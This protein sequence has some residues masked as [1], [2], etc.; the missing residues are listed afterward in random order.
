[1][2]LGWVIGWVI[3]RVIGRWGCAF[4]DCLR[5]QLKVV[6][7]REID[8]FGVWMLWD[9]GTTCKVVDALWFATSR[10]DASVRFDLQICMHANDPRL[11]IEWAI[12]LLTNT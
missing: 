3:G 6:G 5:A 8:G 12:C 4:G 1:M 7:G 9:C 2:P 11:E 10:V